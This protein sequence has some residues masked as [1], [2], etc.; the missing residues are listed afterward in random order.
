MKTLTN[1]VDD[2]ILDVLQRTG[3]CSLD[4][5]VQQ[6]LH[7][8]WNEVFAAVDQMS[9]EGRIVLRRAPGPSGYLLSLPLSQPAQPIRI[10]SLPVR[11]C[12]GCGY[13]CDEIDPEGGE[14]QWMDAH[15][16]V[17]KYQLRWSALDR[18]DDTCPQCARVLACGYHRASTEAAPAATAASSRESGH[19]VADR[20]L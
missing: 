14:T 3:P 1:T 15:Q 4:N 9:R 6:V 11:F 5:I 16:Y 8:D 20:M 10:T 17:T 18:I 12:V 7:H 13:L 19:L 2:T